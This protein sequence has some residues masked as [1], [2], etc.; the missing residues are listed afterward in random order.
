MEAIYAR[1]TEW[2]RKKKLR[3]IKKKKKKIDASSNKNIDFNSREP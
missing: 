1:E 2:K 3:K